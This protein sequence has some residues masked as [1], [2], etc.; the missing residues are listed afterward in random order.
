MEKSVTN[1]TKQVTDDPEAALGGMLVEGTTGF[2]E[3]MEARGQRELVASTVLPTE[4]SDDPAILEMGVAFGEAVKGDDLFRQATL[5]EG[6]KKVGSDHDMWSY[7]EDATGKRRIAVF[8]K[9]AFYDR[10]AFMRA[11][12]SEAAGA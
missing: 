12:R 10:R 9:A 6:W 1:T 4:G 2:I 3:G 11:E 5:P 8:Y 7:V